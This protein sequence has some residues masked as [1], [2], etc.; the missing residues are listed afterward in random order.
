MKK[1]F[2]KKIA[3]VV[4]V[5]ACAIGCIQFASPVEAQAADIDSTVTSSDEVEYIFIGDSLFVGTSTKVFGATASSDKTV[6]EQIGNQYWCCKSG[7]TLASF[8]STVLDT[9]EY[10]E[11][12]KENITI[13]YELGGNDVSSISKDIKFV[14]KLIKQGWNVYI[15]DILPVNEA[16]Q[17][18]YNFSNSAIAAANEK[19]YASGLPVIYFYDTCLA[20]YQNNTVS[21]G[22]H[23]KKKTYKAWY[24]VIMETVEEDF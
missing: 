5:L 11:Y 18:Y 20:K 17:T 13:V 22:V 16:K 24:K 23:Y 8:K 15:C 19:I 21:D 12:N 1:K 4:L 7:A 2:I 14:K 10:F 6:L 9:L 3:A